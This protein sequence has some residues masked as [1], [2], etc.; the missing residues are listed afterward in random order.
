M[1]YVPI[2]LVTYD[3]RS[4]LS[5]LDRN[6]LIN[7]STKLLVI[8]H[9]NVPRNREVFAER[10]A[11]KPVISKNSA[12]IWMAI[13]HDAEKIECFALEPVCTGPNRANRVD[14]RKSVVFCEHTKPET[15]I[16]TNRKQMRG[17]CKTGPLITP[18]TPA[19]PSPRRAI[20]RSGSSSSPSCWPLAFSLRPMPSP[21]R[22]T[23]SFSTRCSKPSTGR[24][25][26]S[27]RCC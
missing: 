4:V 24:P 26:R 12:Q 19:R 2:V 22:A 13:E 5:R 9:F 27:T 23:S 14:H 1:T 17:D 20:W 10:I 18:R 8:T 21:G 3:T 6:R 11:N 25:A 16:V 15:I 7:N